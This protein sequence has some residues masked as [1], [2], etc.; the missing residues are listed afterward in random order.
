MKGEKRSPSHAGC[1]TKS[2][3]T[4]IHIANQSAHSDEQPCPF[5]HP[6]VMKSSKTSSITGGRLSLEVQAMFDD[7]INLFRL[8]QPMCFCW[9]A[10][11]TPRMEETIRF[12]YVY[13]D[14]D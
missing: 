3:L 7:T 6:F 4:S 8:V 10:K 14:N 9:P 5:T 11:D 12:V 2:K 1:D 13:S